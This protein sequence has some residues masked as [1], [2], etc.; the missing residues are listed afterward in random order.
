MVSGPQPVL[1]GGHFYFFSDDVALRSSTD[2]HGRTRKCCERHAS[3][4]LVSGSVHH[5][6]PLCTTT[7][8]GITGREEAAHQGAIG[9]GNW[10]NDFTTKFHYKKYHGIMASV[11]AEARSIRLQAAKDG[12]CFFVAY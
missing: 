2:R 1:Y 8:A 4:W 11:V 3:K 6:M 5:A 10:N 7:F 12:E 9:V